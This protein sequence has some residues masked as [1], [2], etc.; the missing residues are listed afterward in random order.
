MLGKERRICNLM[1]TWISWVTQ[2]VFT[3]CLHSCG[4]WHCWLAPTLLMYSVEDQ[5]KKSAVYGL[6]RSLHFVCLC[7][8]Q[9]EPSLS[10]QVFPAIDNDH[11]CIFKVISNELFCIFFPQCFQFVVILSDAELA[12]RSPINWISSTKNSCFS[13]SFTFLLDD[14]HQSSS[15][16]PGYWKSGKHFL[17]RIKK[18]IV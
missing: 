11:V 3:H 18:K 6:K 16:P 15:H 4:W 10:N 7:L 1:L 8:S 13:A 17:I 2:M 9:A 12:F 14:L 5:K